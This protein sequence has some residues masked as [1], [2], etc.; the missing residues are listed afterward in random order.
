MISLEYLKNTSMITYVKYNPFLNP[1][2]LC[3]L[4]YHI[5][6]A[7]STQII[8]HT[9]SLEVSLIATSLFLL[10]SNPFAY[11]LDSTFLKSVWCVPA[12]LPQPLSESEFVCTL[13]LYVHL[14]PTDLYVH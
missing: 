12:L 2:L 1:I 5:I 3:L 11:P 9:K 14:Y 7:Q 8:A 10:T 6:T 4:I 13:Y